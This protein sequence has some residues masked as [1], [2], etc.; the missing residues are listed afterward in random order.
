VYTQE[1]IER[2]GLDDFRVFL[3]QV[4]DYL[5]LP[6]PTAVQNDLAFNLQHGPSHLMIEAFR[7]V[8]KSWITVSFVLWHL[9]LDPQKKI[10][11]VSASEDHAI[12]FTT[13]CKRLLDM[14]LLQHLRP[15]GNQRDSN[16]AFDVGPATADLSPSV[17]SVGITGQLTGSRAD[18]IVPDDIETPKNSYAHGLRERIAELIREFG[19]VL[20][21][22][23]RVV[24]LGTPQVE[25]SVY[26]RLPARGYK[27]MVWPA[28]VPEHTEAYHGTLAPFIMRMVERGVP[29]HTPVE[30]TRFP[31]E[32]LD[33]RLAEYGRSG[34]ALQFMLDTNPSE[35]DKHPL[36]LRDLI[37]S[38]LDDT[39]THVRVV[40]SSEKEYG[41]KD[42]TPGGFDGDYYFRPAW[43]SD[44][45]APYTEAIMF[46]DPSGRG[47]DE[48]SY[49]VLK[50]LYSQ[51]HLFAIGGYK[52][53]FAEETLQALA[54]IAARY[55]VTKIIVEPNYG[56]GMFT[57]M[58]RT[59]VMKIGRSAVEDAEWAR[60]MKEGRILDVLEPIIQSHR[61][62][63]D[64]R[65]IEQ[66]LKQQAD[67]SQ[68]S[69]V[70][71]FT[72]MAR[73]KGALAHD[74][75]IEA[76]AGACAYF[77][78]KMGRD[79]AKAHDKFKDS[80]LDQELKN[81]GQN[82]L[83]VGMRVGNLS[84]ASPKRH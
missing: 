50:I 82:V 5:G 15:H 23:G 76:L 11:V 52:A 63:V 16:L 20:K 13:F 25:Q 48:T 51:L 75:R 41:I 1:E 31:R 66:D 67:N 80:L 18:I 27:I 64:R 34:Y 54:G 26:N 57:Q 42:L 62:T 38:Q 43:K 60:G 3:R 70:Q 68:Y 28:E 36:K 30:P 14:P 56:G 17:K 24:Y 72:R 78:D 55:K 69:F 32:E 2:A 39:M 33:K 44:E 37:V 84:Y 81:W 65:V 19:A 71:Q 77:E 6:A 4:W 58:L 35:I 83:G 61:L 45:M 7:G 47:G 73:M 46:V 22:G 79:Q 8:G 9:F 40:H 12:N 21:P 29:A 10:M 59:A 74:D 53:G 49:C